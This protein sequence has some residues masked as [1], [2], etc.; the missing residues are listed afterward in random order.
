MPLLAWLLQFLSWAWGG[1]LAFAGQNWF[2]VLIDLTLTGL[3]LYPLIDFLF[4]GWR[5]RANEITTCLTPKAKQLYLNSFQ[6]IPVTLAQ[7]PGE[8]ERLYREWY[9]RRYHIL[10]I[11][12][13]FFVSI[14][15]DYVL[16]QAL[17]DLQSG[18]GLTTVAA[19][20][21]GAYTFVAGDLFTRMQRRNLSRADILR[22][23]LRLAMALPIG[24]AFANLGTESIAPFLAF[25]VGVFP[26]QELF[27][28]IRRL[29]N[30]KLKL[31]LGADT[32]PDQVKTLAGIDAS[33]ADRIAD[34]DIT[35]ITQLAWCDPIQLT[36]RANLQFNYVLDIVSQ[37]LAW[38]YLE[39]KLEKLRPLGLRGAIEIR[40]L[41][42]EIK[43][44]SRAEKRQARVVLPAAAK[45]AD[46]MSLPGLK[47][48]FHQIGEDPATA[49]LD[50]AR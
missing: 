17:Q 31:E 15:E 33:T 6:Q 24:F 9:G 38:V 36:M 25:A 49:F 5:R 26:I 10:P 16:A 2:L 23:A 27:T 21:A 13:V 34:A 18:K 37:A 4:V 47:Y 30:N 42:T 1:L 43:S 3:I 20:I 35:T 12:F 50:E 46:D 28:I 48:A 8:F 29:A 19:A 39:K 40:I 14:V 45:A 22:S 41:L 32:S 44:G 7:A 11:L